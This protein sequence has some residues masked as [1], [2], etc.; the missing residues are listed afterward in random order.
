MIFDVSTAANMAYDIWK[1]FSAKVS[2]KTR[3][4]AL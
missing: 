4:A 2:K 1:Q 3:G